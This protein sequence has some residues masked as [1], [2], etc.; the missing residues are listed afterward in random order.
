MDRCSRRAA[1]VCLAV[2]VA[3]CT[4]HVVGPALDVPIAASYPAVAS[5]FTVQTATASDS[6]VP[7]I[8]PVG[9]SVLVTMVVPT[10]CGRDTVMAGAARDSLVVTL[11]RTLLPL[12]CAILLP[13][14][15]VRAAAVATSRPRVVVVSVH[16]L[17]FTDTTRALVASAVLGTAP[18]LVAPRE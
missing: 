4:D 18:P 2:A 8:T 12:P 14:V 6:R 7:T 15:R 16:R 11:R 13:D 3:A 1:L 9:D 10:I 5:T 17:D